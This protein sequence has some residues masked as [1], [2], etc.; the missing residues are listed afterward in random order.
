MCVLHICIHVGLVRDE[1]ISNLRDQFSTSFFLLSR[2]HRHTHTTHTHT[3][4]FIVIP[5]CILFF[6]AHSCRTAGF[7]YKS[8]MQIFFFVR[9]FR[10]S[11]PP[12]IGETTAQYK[13]VVPYIGTS[14]PL[15]VH[16]NTMMKVES[17]F[18]KKKKK[19]IGTYWLR[20]YTYIGVIFFFHL[21]SSVYW[22]I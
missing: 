4:T 10:L 9:L 1:I 6:W 12:L 18:E 16:N 14:L 21:L 22:F 5:V 8:W 15:P 13:Y 2:T 20:W 3:H 11:P 7:V 19:C 17:R